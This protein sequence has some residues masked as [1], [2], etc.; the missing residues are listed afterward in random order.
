MR[1]FN[2]TQ[3]SEVAQMDQV[4]K[5]TISALVQTRRTEHVHLSTFF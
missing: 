1:D 4:F 2:K 5:P 3:T